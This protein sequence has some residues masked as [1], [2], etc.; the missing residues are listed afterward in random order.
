MERQICPEY[1]VRIGVPKAP[2]KN[3]DALVSG[4]RAQ[5]CVLLARRGFLRAKGKCEPIPTDQGIFL[6]Y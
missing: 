2:G 1:C 3:P 4:L 5:P 6:R